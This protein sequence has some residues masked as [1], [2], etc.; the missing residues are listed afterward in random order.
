MKMRLLLAG[1]IAALV[2]A[3]CGSS[4]SSTSSSAAPSAAPAATTTAPSAGAPTAATAFLTPLHTVSTIASTVPANGDVN[5]YGIV[6]VP[7]SVGNLQAGDL[8]V[9]NFNNKSAGQGT[10]TTIVQ[11]SPSGK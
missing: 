5:P 11:I 10:G 8:L 1:P 7:A 9:S 2:L 3:G 6:L 4:S